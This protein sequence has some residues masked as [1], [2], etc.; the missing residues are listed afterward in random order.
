MSDHTWISTEHNSTLS[1]LN[2]AANLERMLSPQNTHKED[3]GKYSD[4]HS[5]TFFHPSIL[6]TLLISLSTFS[7][8]LSL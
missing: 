7:V 2:P 4:S 3:D 6:F 1:D 8:Y 5:Y